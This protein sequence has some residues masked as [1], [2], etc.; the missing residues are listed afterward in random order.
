MDMTEAIKEAYA[1]ADPAVTLFDTFEI[2]HS[3]WSSDDYIRLV[4]SDISLET[5]QGA[6]KPAVVNASL[7]ETESSVRG[8]LTITINCLPV[9]YRDQLYAVVLETNPVYIQY[10]Q[11]TGENEAPQAELPVALTVSEIGFKGDF[12]TVLTCLYP[13]LVNIPFCRKVM[14]TTIFP[15]GKV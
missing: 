2:S 6:F 12:E 9:A 1:Y 14:T 4:D 11:Y 15:G 5:P 10:R 7:P 3:T 13:D 8:E